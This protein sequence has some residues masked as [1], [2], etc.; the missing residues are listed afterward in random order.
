MFR[1]KLSGEITADIFKRISQKNRDEQTK[2]ISEVEQLERKLNE[3][4]RVRQDM[5][6]LVTRIKECLIIG[7][8]VQCFILELQSLINRRYELSIY[9]ILVDYS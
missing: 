7:N 5:G 4:L 8:F 2:L 3:G 1:R 9:L 6:G